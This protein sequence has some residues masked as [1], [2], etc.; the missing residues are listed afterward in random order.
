MHSETALAKRIK[1]HVL[2]KTGSFYVSTLPGIEHLCVD[3][4]TSAGISMANATLTIGGVEFPGRVHECYLANL[5]LRM[6]RQ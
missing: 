2:G 6:E 1:R 3:E 5:H 4:L